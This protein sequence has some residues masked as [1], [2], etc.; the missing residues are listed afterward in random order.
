MGVVT[1]DRGQSHE[2]LALLLAGGGHRCRRWV[3]AAGA[4][5]PLFDLLLA[6]GVPT[7]L[8]RSARHLIGAEVPT[9]LEVIQGVGW[10]W[11]VPGDG[12]FP[13][14][15]V[16]TADPPLG[17][18]VR[19]RLRRGRRVT[20]VG[21]RRASAYGRQAARLLGE[22]MAHAGVVVVSGMARGVDAAAHEGA[23]AST[24]ETWAIWGTG[25]DRIYP[26]EHARLAEQ[27]AAH[28]ALMTE[29]P[30]G[31]PPRR[32]HFPERNRLLAGVA[33]AVV[34]VEAAARSGALVTARLAVDEG[35]E[36]FAVP[37]S[38]FS[39]LSIGPNTLLRLGARPLLTPNDVLR[40]LQIPSGTAAQPVSERG[41]ELRQMLATGEALTA[42]EL[43]ARAGRPVAEVLQLVLQWEL[44]GLL[45]RQRDGRYSL[46]RG[47][48]L[49]GG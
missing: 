40:L 9:L 20:V 16:T 3:A 45:E 2:R 49:A 14:L 31:T 19:G 27:I 11:I 7:A 12:E 17:L 18:F 37:G 41:H 32:H 48:D 8:V 42:D 44:D 28:G 33:D 15:L 38:I 43:A 26:P 39:D 25:P 22:A 36:V 4:D 29:Y 1:T 35:R 46:T 13:E 21:S 5:G 23:I 24:G 6:R 47:I 10:R 30:P 34:V